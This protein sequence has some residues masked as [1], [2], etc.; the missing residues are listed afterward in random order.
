MPGAMDPRF[1][2]TPLLKPNTFSA[3]GSSSLQHNLL[4]TVEADVNRPGWQRLWLAVRL[5]RSGGRINAEVV[6]EVF[7]ADYARTSVARCHIE[8]LFRG[9]R[10]RVLNVGRNVTEVHLTRVPSSTLMS[11]RLNSGPTLVSP[12]FSSGQAARAILLARRPI[13]SD[14]PSVTSRTLLFRHFS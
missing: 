5:Q 11:Y 7:I 13:P 8:K 9:M 12:R 3:P 10:P 6:R 14:R 1:V 4:R 2:I